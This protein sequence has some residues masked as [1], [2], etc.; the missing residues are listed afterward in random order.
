MQIRAARASSDVEVGLI[1][2]R[3]R[4]TLVEVLGKE[5]AEEMYS[6]E[7][8]RAR[9]RF[10]LDPGLCHAAVYLAE[11]DDGRVLGQSILRIEPARPLAAASAAEEY[12]LMATI[13]VVPEARRS[14]IAERLV[15][16]VEAWI[17]SQGLSRAATNTGQHN[18]K[19]IRLFEKRGYTISLRTG[20]ML[21]LSRPL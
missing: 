5:R 3:M 16:Q 9:V 19:L 4:L 12:G 7:W 21:Q 8:L 20:D 11:A 2:S 15:E 6:Q 1:A 17:R 18:E 13:Y 10:H 14:G